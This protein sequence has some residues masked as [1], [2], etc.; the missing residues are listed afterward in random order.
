MCKHLLCCSWCVSLVCAAGLNQVL[1][2][3]GNT[4]G[5]SMPRVHAL[6]IIRMAFSNTAL[7]KDISEFLQRGV[8]PCPWLCCMFGGGK[9]V[10]LLA[11]APHWPSPIPLGH[12]HMIVMQRA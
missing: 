2:I 9:L 10:V 12:H 5:E 8:W 3:A 1:Q 6:N 11:W 7:A 4:K